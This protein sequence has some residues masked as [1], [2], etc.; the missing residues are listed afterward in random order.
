MTTEQQSGIIAR[1]REI[2][3]RPRFAEWKWNVFFQDN[4]FCVGAVSSDPQWWEGAA[5]PVLKCT[6][7]YEG[8]FLK[9]IEGMSSQLW[10]KKHKPCQS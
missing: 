6:P 1:A 10:K 3:N 9:L 4:Y 8:V 5:I 2:C 7:N